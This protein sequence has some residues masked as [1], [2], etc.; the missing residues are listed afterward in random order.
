MI[1]QRLIYASAFPESV[2]PVSSEEVLGNRAH[3]Y[4]KNIHGNISFF[5]ALLVGSCEAMK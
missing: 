3:F 1:L 2:V 5:N 4:L